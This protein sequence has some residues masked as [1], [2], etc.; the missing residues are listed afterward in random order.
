M[1]WGTARFEE[2][3]QLEIGQIV[4]KEHPMKL[5]FTRAKQIK[6]GSFRSAL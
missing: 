6:Q 5:R 4:K 3:R 2:V 1:Y